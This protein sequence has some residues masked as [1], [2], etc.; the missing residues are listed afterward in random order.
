[1]IIHATFQ[2][3]DINDAHD[4]NRKLSEIGDS[5]DAVDVTFSI[6]ASEE[7]E[8]SSM[9]ALVVALFDWYRRN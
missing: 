8:I 2:V 9:N 3:V 6:M 7:K 5:T 4:L 1:M